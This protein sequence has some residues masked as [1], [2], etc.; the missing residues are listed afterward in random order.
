MRRRAADGRFPAALAGELLPEG[1]LEFLLR[2]ALGEL[3]RWPGH[4]MPRL[5]GDRTRGV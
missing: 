4:T 5:R 3:L 2:D 1:L